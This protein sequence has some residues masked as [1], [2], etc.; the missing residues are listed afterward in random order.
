MNM[1][2]YVKK[3]MMFFSVSLLFIIACT[4]AASYALMKNDFVNND[5][6]VNNK[7][8]QVIYENRENGIIDSL[9]PLSFQQGNLESPSNFIKIVNK[10]HFSTKFAIVIKQ[11][12]VSIDTLDINKIYYSVNNSTPKILGSVEDGV[13]FTSKVNG[14]EEYIADVKL[15]ISSELIDNSDAGKKISLDI[16]VIEK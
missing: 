4:V 8:L 13:I 1:G 14:K 12:N 16:Q 11:T 6:I 15:W 5:V 2:K 7:N 3:R 10:K 9:Y